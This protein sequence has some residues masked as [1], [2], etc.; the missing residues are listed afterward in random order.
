MKS[1]VTLT[2]YTCDGCGRTVLAN[3]EV[4]GPP[5]GYHGSVTEI[6]GLG[7]NGADWYAHQAACIRKAVT[8]ALARDDR[9]D[10]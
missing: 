7:G 3:E 8:N 2:E 1:A 4:D 10:E 9:Y 5:Y 6:T